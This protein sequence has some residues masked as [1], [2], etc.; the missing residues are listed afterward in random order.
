MRL[1]LLLALIGLSSC[2]KKDS[3]MN[4]L[5]VRVNDTDFSKGRLGLTHNIT[6]DDLEAFHGHLCD[7]LVVGFLGLKEGLE[8]LYPD[9]IVDRTN[10]RVVSK[11]SP[12]LTDAAAYLTG[13]RMQ[14]S[15]F[16]VTDSISSLFVIQRI[17]NGN[18]IAVKLKAGVKP[19]RIDKLGKLAVKQ[20]LS[21]CELDELKNLEDDF[22]EY[23]LSTDPNENFDIEILDSFSWNPVLRNDFVKTD[24]L[25]KDAGSCSR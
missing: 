25:N 10:T 8:K 14:F 1:L 4:E 20:Q 7:G 16:Y 18:A 21:A 12:C 3:H 22:S 15:T 19:A 17:D 6:L 11:P 24:I 5:F 13:G 9:G 23:L 2:V